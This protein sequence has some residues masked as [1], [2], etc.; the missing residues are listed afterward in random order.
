MER[1]KNDFHLFFLGD[2]VDGLTRFANAGFMTEKD[3]NGYVI[4]S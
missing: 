3:Y 2:D 4:S 1:W